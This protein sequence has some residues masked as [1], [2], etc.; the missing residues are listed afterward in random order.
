MLYYYY[1]YYCNNNI[2]NQPM[3]YVK[4]I[5]SSVNFILTCHI[6]IQMELY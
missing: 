5:Q 1:Y 3:R 6:Y 2:D 4:K